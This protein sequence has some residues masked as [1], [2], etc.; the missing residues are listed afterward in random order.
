MLKKRTMLAALLSLAVVMTAA[1][2]AMMRKRVLREE[3]HQTY[4]FSAQGRIS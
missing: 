3:F 2:S 4:P 1:S